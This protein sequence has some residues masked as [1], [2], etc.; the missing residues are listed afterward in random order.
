MTNINNKKNK[1]WRIG[2]AVLCALVAVGN[3]IMMVVDREYEGVPGMIFPLVVMIIV[4]N[5]DKKKEY[6][7]FG[8]LEPRQK[9]IRIAFLVIALALVIS[10]VVV[11]FTYK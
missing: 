4:M 1:I 9:R 6:V 3:F 8:E 7:S 5:G 10:G 11:A 2:V